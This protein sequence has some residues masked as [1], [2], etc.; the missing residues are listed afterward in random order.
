MSADAMKGQICGPLFG[1]WTDDPYVVVVV[2]A[3]GQA[4]LSGEENWC[5]GFSYL[6]RLARH[7]CDSDP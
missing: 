7:A 5:T 1:F 4:Y 3:V 6:T 2:S